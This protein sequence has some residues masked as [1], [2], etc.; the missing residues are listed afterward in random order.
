MSSRKA[1]LLRIAEAMSAGNIDHVHDWFTED[2]KLH[3]PSF[4]GFRSG[5][6]GALD[7]L[8]S[9]AEHVPGAAINALGPEAITLAEA[10][11]EL[12]LRPIGRWRPHPAVRI[13][14]VVGAE[15]QR[16]IRRPFLMSL[17]NNTGT[18]S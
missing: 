16:R 5:L 3:D 2:F 13:S 15:C 7:M 17:D 18:R 8:R 4:G 12:R 1:V 14:Y 9:I 10:E 6:E 11:G